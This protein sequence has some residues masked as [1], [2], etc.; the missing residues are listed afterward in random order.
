M[1]I[2][3]GDHN[4]SDPILPIGG[5]GHNA[6][7]ITIGSD[8]WLGAHC[9]I[10]RDVKVGDGAVVAAGAVVVDDVPPRTVV[11]GVP[12]VPKKLRGAE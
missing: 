5:Q 7:P 11:A 10:L 8:V 12:A 3:S 9:V 6:G 4:Y 2:N 1:V